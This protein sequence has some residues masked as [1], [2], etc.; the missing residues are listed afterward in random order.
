MQSVLLNFILPLVLRLLPQ[1]SGS[2]RSLMVQHVQEWKAHAA[3]TSNPLDDVAVALLE[4][5]LSIEPASK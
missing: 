4:S 3:T 2:L 1:V 5:V